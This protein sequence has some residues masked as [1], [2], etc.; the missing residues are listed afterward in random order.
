MIATKPIEFRSN[1]KKY[2]DDAYQGEPVVVVRP[3]NENVVV[4]SEQDY[5]ALLKAK[6][7]AEYLA[8][9]DRSLDELKQGKTIS[10]SLD[11]LRSME[12]ESWK[13]SQKILDFVE[14][15]TDE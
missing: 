6:A 9:L 8:R 7:N 10:L 11:E 12:N 1:L 15:M 14:R 5:N 3:R 2:M 13:P 4:V